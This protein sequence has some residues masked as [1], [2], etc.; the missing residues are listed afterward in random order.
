M[1]RGAGG[2]ASGWW[3]TTAPRQRAS[4]AVHR[5]GRPASPLPAAC[6]PGSRR[7]AGCRAS[8]RMTRCLPPCRTCAAAPSGG[9]GGNKSG[10][11]RAC[12]LGAARGAA[13]SGCATLLHPGPALPHLWRHVVC[14]ANDVR[15]LLPRL[16]EHRQPKVRGLRDTAAAAAARRGRACAGACAARVGHAARLLRP[17]AGVARRPR[18]LAAGAQRLRRC[19][20]GRGQGG[21]VV[22]GAAP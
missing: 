20:G 13:R 18:W 8:R 17:A 3:G 22:G 21:G 6:P 15:K 11:G 14:A 12:C 1:W 9:G 16:E 10:R 2:W 19:Q 4:G 7:T 5:A